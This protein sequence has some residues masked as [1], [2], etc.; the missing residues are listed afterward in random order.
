MNKFLTIVVLI[1]VAT[2]YGQTISDKQKIDDFKND[3]LDKLYEPDTL[4]IDTLT[5][6]RER[7]PNVRLVKTFTKNRSVV[8]Y[9]YYYNGR[10]QL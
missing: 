6:V 10:T 7:Y 4:R 5:F 2:A 8:L 9:D 3:F 1:N